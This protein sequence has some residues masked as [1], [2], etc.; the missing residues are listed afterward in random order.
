MSFHI[1]FVQD[2]LLA[3]SALFSIVNPIG[4]A[5]I[6]NEVTKSRTHAQRVILSKRIALYSCIVM[7]CSLWIGAYVLKFFGISITALRL[8]GGF[9]VAATAWQMLSSPERREER[10][11]QQ[12][13]SA[14]DDDIAFV[15]LTIPVTTGPGTI[16]V[17]IALGSNHPLDDLDSLR[18]ALGTGAAAVS[19]AAAVWI[20]YRAADRLVAFVG[21]AGA[22]TLSRLAAFLLLCVGVQIA[23]NGLL[24]VLYRH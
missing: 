7:L 19:I 9:V 11:E 13:D 21:P 17:A 8:A 23:L 12:A 18:F 6:F 22:R 4:S 16:A 3:F 2:F 20:C 5:L 1:L 24:D 14:R 15:P 10:K